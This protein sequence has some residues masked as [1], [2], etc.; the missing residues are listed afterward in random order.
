MKPLH[1]PTS[2]SP[3]RADRNETS[4]RRPS[5]HITNY[6]RSPEEP[7]HSYATVPEKTPSAGNSFR[8]ISRDYWRSENRAEF[9]RELVLFAVLT[10]VSA[11]PLL[12]M[13]QALLSLGE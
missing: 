8:S 3:T 2:Q 11:W 9:A 5:S 12:T 6:Y 7:R 10:L 1:I 4:S 13:A